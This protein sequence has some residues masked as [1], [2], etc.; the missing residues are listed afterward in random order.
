MIPQRQNTN[1]KNN[2]NQTK[3]EP[4]FT[5][6]EIPKPVLEHLPEKVD[7]P[8]HHHN[9]NQED[10]HKIHNHTQ[11]DIYKINH[12]KY[13]NSTKDIE[14]PN[15]YK[16]DDVHVKEGEVHIDSTIIIGNK[17]SEIYNSK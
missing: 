17:P 10:D 4:A 12:T 14:V 8:I 2:T 7:E 3:I 1:D 11:E 5:P 16:H 13:N 9:L 15:V 6:K